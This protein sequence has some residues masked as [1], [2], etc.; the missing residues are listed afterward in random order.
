MRRRTIEAL[1]GRPSDGFTLI[2]VMVAMF[3]T[4]IVMTALIYS[5]V[6]SL[7]T[8]QQARQRQ[9]ATALAT[10]Q[11]ERLRAEPY[12]TVTQ[13]DPAFTLGSVAYTTTSGGSTTFNPPAQLVPGGVSEPLVINS[14]SGQALDQQVGNVTYHVQ[15]YVTKAP[16]TD[17]SGTQPF[18][19]TAIVTWR[20]SVSRGTRELVQRS[21]TFSSSGCLSTA[22]SPFAAPCQAYYTVRAGEAL[23]GV[24]VS[25]VT[26]P[27]ALIQ[28]MGAKQLQLDLSHTSANL[29]V[30]QTASGTASAVTSGAS[31]T[32]STNSTTGGQSAGAVVD[33]DP[34]SVP[35]QSVTSTTPS[36]TAA[37]LTTTSGPG[38]TLSVRPSTSDS[39]GAQA[40]IQ[41]PSSLCTDATGSGLVTGLTGAERPCA[42]SM[43]Q[44]N[45][46][47]AVLTYTS[48]T[49]TAL[50]LGTFGIATSPSRAVAALLGAT[51]LGV[52]SAGGSVDCGH[53]AASRSQGSSSF[54]ALPFSSAPGGFDASTGLWNVSGI[55]ESAVA[56]EGSGA[57]GG[58]YTRSGQVKVWNGT[59]YQTISLAFDGST[60]V[61]QTVTIQ[62]TTIG[63]AGGVSVRYDGSVTVQRPSIVRTPTSAARTGNVNTDCKTAACITS[64]N[65]SSGVSARVTV[66]VSVGGTQVTSFATTVDLGGLTADSSFKAAAN[67]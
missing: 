64:V 63:Y 32:A 59:A 51:N 54:G 35:G 66:T 11:L 13:P 43:L 34:S 62:P 28:G 61:Q 67:A 26:D 17:T 25:N 39:G 24:T 49:G 18:N 36:Q 29:L 8:I 60:P 38:G 42:A 45:G 23:S 31:I 4:T 65:G 46:S 15:T 10:Q 12:D 57:L 48:P 7:A 27:T 52:C 16:L 9:T 55:Q 21:T 2:E 3:V 5:V 33:S 20:S 50:D 22:N 47:S 58:S 44:T 1:R 40:A 53:A 14:V 6:Q 19:L 37:T 56:E 41:A 30:E